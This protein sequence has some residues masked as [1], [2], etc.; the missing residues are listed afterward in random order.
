MSQSDLRI[1]FG[2]GDATRVTLLEIRWPTGQVETF[3]NLE[4]DQLIYVREGKGIIRTE[5]WPQKNKSRS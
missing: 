3:R 2:L 1:H 4:V 5:Q